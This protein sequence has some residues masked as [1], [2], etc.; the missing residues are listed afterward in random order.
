MLKISFIDSLSKRRLVLE[1]KLIAPWADELR[2]ACDSAMADLD[3]RELVIDLR[4]I[5]AISREGEDVLL[6]FMHEGIKFRSHDVFAKHVLK[7]LSRKT[8]PRLQEVKE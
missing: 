5:T 3:H 4:N 6:E 2:A 7:Q 1:G 8:K